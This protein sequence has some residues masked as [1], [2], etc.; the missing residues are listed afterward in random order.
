MFSPE[1]NKLLDQVQLMKPGVQRDSM[2]SRIVERVH[3]ER[4]RERESNPSTSTFGPGIWN[5]KRAKYESSCDECGKIIHKG[6]ICWIT[7]GSSPRCLECDRPESG[8]KIQTW[9]GTSRYT[10]DSPEKARSLVEQLV[11]QLNALSPV[12]MR[13]IGYRYDG[14]VVTIRYTNR[15]IGQNKTDCTK[16]FQRELEK[17]GETVSREDL[18]TEGI[19]TL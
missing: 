10:A 19:T 5:Q 1:L 11:E 18:T 4:E 9:S 15:T 12:E 13:T 2:C 14:P 3:V 6:T 7:V 8:K 16:F 17:C